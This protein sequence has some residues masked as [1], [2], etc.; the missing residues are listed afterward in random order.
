MQKLISFEFT[1]L[2]LKSCFHLSGIIRPGMFGI[3]SWG[4]PVLIGSLLAGE[5][6]ADFTISPATEVLI[7]LCA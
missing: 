7:D 6:S 5:E 1:F 2:V 4:L 3:P